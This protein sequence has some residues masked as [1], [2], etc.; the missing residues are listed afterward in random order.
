MYASSLSSASHHNPTMAPSPLPPNILHILLQYISPPSELTQPIPPHLLSKPLLQRH[1]FLSITPDTPDDYL[2]WSPSPEKKARALELLESRPRP[3]DDDQPTA[4]PVQYSFDGEDFFAHVDLSCGTGD[5]PRI[6][7]Q[8]DE[9]GDWRYHNVDLMPFPPGSRPLLEDVLIPPPLS[10]PVQ[11]RATP[12]LVPGFDPAFVDE[13]DGDD[14]DY[15]NAYGSTDIGDSAYSDGAPTS[16]KDVQSSEDAYWAQY[17]SV[18]GKL[19]N[20]AEMLLTVSYDMRMSY[21]ENV[22]NI[23]SLCV[24]PFRNRGLYHTFSSPSKPSQTPS[25]YSHKRCNNKR[26]NRFDVLP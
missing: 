21:L 19:Q 24:Y 2:C 9:H 14:D 22:S 20:F 12:P 10:V 8:W 23:F 11:T 4:Y 26:P 1:H 3:V 13:D 25:F 7:L 17:A 6:V 5:G 16:A 18:Q 15:W